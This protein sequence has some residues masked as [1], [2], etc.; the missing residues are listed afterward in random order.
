MGKLRHA[1]GKT[2]SRC[3]FRQLP[4]AQPGPFPSD[5]GHQGEEQGCGTACSFR[6]GA[7]LE[8]AVATRARLSQ[9]GRLAH[10]TFI[11]HSPGGRHPRS[12]PWADPLPGMHAAT[13]SL[14]AQRMER[15]RWSVVHFLEGHRSSCGTPLPDG[16]SS[17]TRRGPASNTPHCGAGLQHKPG[18]GGVRGARSARDTALGSVMP[19]GGNNGTT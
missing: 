7:G 1:R 13:F 8:T 3:W 14:C 16:T 6:S 15:A 19:Q 5:L 11:W 18:Q 17:Q 4:D 2:G 10:Q 12:G 9:P